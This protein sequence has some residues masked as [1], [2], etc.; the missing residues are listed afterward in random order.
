MG[1][2]LWR[3]ILRESGEGWRRVNSTGHCISFIIRLDY[4]CCGMYGSAYSQPVCNGWRP[5]AKISK[6]ECPFQH[7][8]ASHMASFPVFPFPKSRTGYFS[9]RCEL[10]W[11]LHSQVLGC[12]V[13][14]IGLIQNRLCN[15]TNTGGAGLI[16]E[17]VERI[18]F[19]WGMGATCAYD[20]QLRHTPLYCCF[21]ECRVAMRSSPSLA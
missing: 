6:E 5:L 21:T 14:L 1:T 4:L 7:Y 19:C 15:I 18:L 20:F 16:L 17:R 12:F 9:A 10:H 8:N 3:N 11:I 13:H 2:D